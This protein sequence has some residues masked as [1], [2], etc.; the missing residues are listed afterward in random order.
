VNLTLGRTSGDLD[1]GLDP[2]RIIIHVIRQRSA[3]DIWKSKRV[4]VLAS[5]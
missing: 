2:A 1:S 5:M 3:I 4:V